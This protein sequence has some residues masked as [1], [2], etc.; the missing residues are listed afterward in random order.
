LNAVLKACSDADADMFGAACSPKDNKELRRAIRAA[1]DVGIPESYIQRVLQMAKQGVK[2][3]IFREYDTDWNSEAYATVSG[4]NS[5]NSV[6][7]SNAFLE[8]VEQDTDWNLTARITNK[9]TRTLPARELWDK[10]AYAAWSCAD[11]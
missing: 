4:Q 3:I 1:R 7:L 11:P 8:A 6:R 10:I 2:E 5:N 9:V